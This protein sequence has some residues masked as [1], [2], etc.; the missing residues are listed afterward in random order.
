MEVYLIAGSR[1]GTLKV[2]RELAAQLLLGGESPLG[3][4]HEP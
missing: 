2:G 1:V 3:Q 4:V